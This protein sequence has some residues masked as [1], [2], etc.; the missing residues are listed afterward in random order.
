MFLMLN[1]KDIIDMKKIL[2]TVIFFFFPILASESHGGFKSNTNAE[3]PWPRGS[4]ILNLELPDPGY[5]S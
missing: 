1:L 2:K 3:I 5:I 4:D